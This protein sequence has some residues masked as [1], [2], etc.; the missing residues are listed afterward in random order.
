MTERTTLITALKKTIDEALLP[1][2]GNPR[3]LILLD[4]PNYANV[5]DSAIYLGVLD[6]FKTH[7]KIK[8]SVASDCYS[9]PSEEI[10]KIYL[11][12][13]IFLHG[14]GN[15]GDLWPSHQK[16]RESI[17]EKYPD[18]LIV[19]LPQ[20]IHYKDASALARSAQVINK[21]KNFVLFVRDEASFQLA[22]TH[23]T[24][25]VIK[26]PDM[27]FYMQKM[28]K[29]AHATHPLLVLLRND[30]E[31]SSETIEYSDSLPAGTVVTDWIH[32]KRG[33]KT[34]ARIVAVIKTVVSGDFR[35]MPLKVNY[36]ELLA[37]YRLKRGTDLLSSSKFIITDRLHTHILS[38]LLDIPHIILDNNYG[39]IS[40]FIDLWT[41][42]YKDLLQ[43]KTVSAALERF[44]LQI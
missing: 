12:C 18:R 8:P 22:K 15:F 43:E 4:F 13:P 19:Q 9:L 34:K 14:G 24:C 3:N 35:K 37:K 42:N 21:H 1:N 7:F 10:T 36:F 38:L 32:D 20:S 28:P 25:K 2:I 31:K 33:M 26:C 17:L 30:V 41:K 29:P 39:K 5:G 16:Y 27:A 44:K 11:Q 40:R 6:F 23:F